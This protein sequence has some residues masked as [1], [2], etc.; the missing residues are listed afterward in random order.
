M[1]DLEERVAVRYGEAKQFCEKLRSMRK[2]LNA[3]DQVQAIDAAQSV[4]DVNRASFFWIF[5]VGLASGRKMLGYYIYKYIY[6]LL[7]TVPSK[8]WLWECCGMFCV[9]HV[10]HSLCLQFLRSRG[11]MKSHH[12]FS[13]SFFLKSCVSILLA[14]LSHQF[15]QRCARQAGACAANRG[16]Y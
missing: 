3:R 14:S 9:F 13:C 12:S 8:G 4:V 5:C 6:L 16:G 10:F 2:S 11:D 15:H 7:F 1:N